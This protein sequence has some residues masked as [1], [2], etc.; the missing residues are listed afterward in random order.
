LLPGVSHLAHCTILPGSIKLKVMSRQLKVESVGS[1]GRR[2]LGVLDSSEV[3][4]GREGSDCGLVI[5]NEA[6]SSRHGMFLGVRNHWLYRDLG[7]TNGSWLNG[8]KLKD[9]Q[10]KLVRPG[11]ALQLANTLLELSHVGA[12]PVINKQ[13]PGGGRSLLVFRESEFIEEYP[14][15]EYG[16]ALVIGGSNGDLDL[17]GDVSEGPSLVVERRGNVVCAYSVAKIMPIRHNEVQVQELVELSDSDEL[18]V[19]NYSILFSNPRERMEAARKASGSASMEGEPSHVRDWADSDSE[20]N[21]PD[22]AAADNKDDLT[23]GGMTSSSARRQ[24]SKQLF[25]NPN[26]E[27]EGNLEETIS[28]SYSDM[29]ERLSGSDVH[30]SMRHSMM[31]VT[32]RPAR[33]LEDTI[34]ILAFIFLIVL[35]FAAI[36]FWIFG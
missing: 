36:V 33:S 13:K 24:V 2:E 3:I 12:A 11:D 30:P 8:Q 26:D 20:T 15:P 7:S 25:G 16:K 27:D 32:E 35:I 17:E 4:V 18:Q 23:V 29:E 28:M 34:Y 5:P 31:D 22:F 21:P 6:V 19:G 1:K 14:V 10:W 9:G